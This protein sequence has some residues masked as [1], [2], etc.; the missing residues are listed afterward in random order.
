MRV[1][2][3]M[4]ADVLAVSSA[5][6]LKEVAAQLAGRSISGVPVV[7][8]GVVVGIVSE[9]DLVAKEEAP[10][11]ENVRKGLVQRLLGPRRRSLVGAVTAGEAMHA[12]AVVVEPWMSASAAAWLMVENDVARLPVLDHGKLV[13][14]VTRRDLVRAFARSDEDIA[15][16]LRTEVLPSLGLGGEVTVSVER[17]RVLLEGEVPEAEA[18]YVPWAARRVIGVVDV[19]SR[20]RVRAHTVTRAPLKEERR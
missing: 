14:I 18:Q 3:V 1:Q 15:R 13:G 10:E 5:T 20:L 16:E 19:D 8:D 4:T 11:Q 12:P 9:S 7:A 17:G 2:D 6:P